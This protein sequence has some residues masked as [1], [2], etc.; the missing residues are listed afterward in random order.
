MKK[1][2]IGTVVLVTMLIGVAPSV[3]DVETTDNIVAP[4]FDRPA[5]ISIVDNTEIDGGADVPTPPLDPYLM[6]TGL[7]IPV[8]DSLT[9]QELIYDSSYID[10]SQGGSFKVDGT[11][12]DGITFG[13]FDSQTITF[14]VDATDQNVGEYPMEIFVTSNADNKTYDLGTFTLTI[15]N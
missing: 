11:L 4:S 2:I 10:W 5:D 7:G 8:G 13:N 14:S 9:D 3:A 15:F 1:I 6:S 12:P